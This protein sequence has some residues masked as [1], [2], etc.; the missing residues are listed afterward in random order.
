MCFFIEGKDTMIF[1]LC[2]F[3]SIWLIGF[4][5]FNIIDV[6]RSKSKQKNKTMEVS[7]LIMRFRLDPRK[8]NHKKLALV[9]SITNSFIIA[10]VCTIISVIPV[11]LIWQMLIGFVLLFALIMLFYELIGIGCVKKGWRKNGNK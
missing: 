4:I 3:A 11:K 5:V 6:K 7:Y 2:F 1:N 9:T 8:I 10:F